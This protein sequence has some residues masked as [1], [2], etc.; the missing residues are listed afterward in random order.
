MYS[1]SEH[2]VKRSLGLMAQDALRRCCNN[3]VEAK[4]V[5]ARSIRNDRRL[6]GYDPDVLSRRVLEVYYSAG[7]IDLADPR[8]KGQPARPLERDQSW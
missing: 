2:D 4:E 6:D 5:M 3:R 7:T 8:L 1:N